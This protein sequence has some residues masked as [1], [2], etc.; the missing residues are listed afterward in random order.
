MSRTI[1]K[2]LDPFFETIGLLA[3]CSRLD[4]IREETKKTLSEA[5][6]DGEKFYEQHLSIF[7]IYIKTFTKHM[8]VSPED[9]VFFNDGDSSYFL[10]LLSLLIDNKDLLPS[11]D[12]LDNKEINDGII[13]IYEALFDTH[14]KSVKLDSFTEIIQFIDS[15]DLSEQAK[16]KLMRIMQDPKQMLQK[17]V[18]A[19]NNNLEAYK[20]ALK[21]INKPLSMLTDEYYKTIQDKSDRVFNKLQDSLSKTSVIY[22][23]MVF[24]LSQMIFEKSCYYGLLCKKVLKD[25]QSDQFSSKESLQIKL[26]AISDKSKLEIL[27]SLKSSPKYNLEIAE[28]LGLTAATMSHHMSVLLTCGFVGVEKRNG[29]VYYNLDKTAAKQFIEELEQLLL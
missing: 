3:L 29:R 12:K 15:T 11:I 5:G 24:P 8:V 6:Y 21:E 26:K 20:K 22:P 2:E 28:Q 13:E 9:L 27:T 19:I 1:I 4:K 18:A 25:E 14:A 10:I 7:E 17:L 16:W 23:T